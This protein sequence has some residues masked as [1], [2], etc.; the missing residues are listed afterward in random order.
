MEKKQFDIEQ[1]TREIA[2]EDF[3]VNI[4]EAADRL[5][6][7]VEFAQSTLKNLYLINGG[8]LV[9]LLTFI[10]NTGIDFD[11]LAMWW[12]FLW[13]AL[14]LAA[15]MFAHLGAYFS[16]A[17]YMEQTFK[18]AWN[19]QLRAKGAQENF[20]FTREY[21]L[22]NFWLYFGVVAACTSLFM[23]IVGTFVGLDGLA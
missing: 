19:A 2:L 14:G 9:A 21:R 5:R 13:F 20:D 16:Q 3:R 22:G 23:F 18:Q 4:D 8:A 17:Y 1:V 6:F 11:Q 10:G 15:S 7:Q 12:S